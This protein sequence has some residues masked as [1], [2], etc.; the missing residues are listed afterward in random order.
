MEE[1]LHE[2]NP[3]LQ[4]MPRDRRLDLATA[5]N[6]GSNIQDAL[7]GNFLSMETWSP[8]VSKKMKVMVCVDSDLAPPTGTSFLSG[9]FSCS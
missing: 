6:Y 4:F 1:T 5:K 2:L 7:W 8:M 3:S 9:C